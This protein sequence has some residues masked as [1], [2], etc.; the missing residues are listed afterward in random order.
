MPSSTLK[1]W[2]LHIALALLMVILVVV[3]YLVLQGFTLHLGRVRDLDT[4]ADKIQRIGREI[5][6]VVNSQTQLAKNTLDLL[7]ETRL[8]A[9]RQHHERLAVATSLATTLRNNPSA[10]SVYAGT[11]NGSFVMLRPLANDAARAAVQAPA[12]AAYLLQSVDRDDTTAVGSFF[13]FNQK[14]QALTS[15]IGKS[16]YQFDPRTRP[17]YS[18]AM[19]TE[20]GGQLV[21]T[22]PYAFFTTREI[23]IT[24]ASR[25]QDRHGVVGMDLNLSTLSAL[26]GR[27][28]ITA[29]AELVLFDA[30]GTVLAYPQ[31]KK[32]LK[33][34]PDGKLTPVTVTELA[35][36]VLAEVWQ[37]WQ[38][39]QSALEQ[40]KPGQAQ[41]SQNG[42]DWFYQVAPIG[43]G[44]SG[45][46]LGFAAPYSELM[47]ESIHIRNLS[48]GISLLLL[49][50]M[51]PAVF[52]AARSV[53][54]P[55]RGLTEVAAAIERFEFDGPDPAPSRITEVDR[56]ARSMRQMKHTLKRFLD[57]S[58]A[59]SSEGNFNK[60][61]H[62]ILRETISVTGAIGGSLALVSADGKRLE[63]QA[64]QLGGQE[65]EVALGGN[66]S[67]TT[68]DPMTQEVQAVLQSQLQSNRFDRND[69]AYV[70]NYGYLFDALDQDL[71]HRIALPLR[72]RAQEVIGVLT[73]SLPAPADA[74]AEPLSATLL[75]FIKAL[76]GTAAVAIDN[77][78]LLL[79]QKRLFES[80]IQLV[81]GS[82]DAKS[83]YTGG[84][85][86]R[87]PELTKMLAHAAQA[88][89]QGP[90]ADYRLSDDE[91]EALHIAG[92][93]HDCGK[94]TTPEFVVDKATKLETIYDRIH[95]VRMRF[96]VLK[97]DARIQAYEQALGQMPAELRAIQAEL[98]PLLA[99]L[100]EEFAFVATCNVG[101][102]FMAP[103]K[104]Q[105]LRN[106]AQRQWLRTL[107]DRAGISQDEALRKA[108]VPAEPLPVWEPLLADKPDQ[109]FTR[110]A[111]ERIEADN[112]WGFKI[113]P[114]EYL[115]HRGELHNLSVGR[116]TLTE[117]DRYKINEHIVQT[118]KMLAQL[119]FPKHLQRV[120]EIA[121]GHH[122]KMDGS[123]YPRKLRREE[124]SLEA[125]MMAIADVFEALTAVDR[126]YKKGK[127]LS[128][129]V[130]I[131]G[132][133]KKDQHIDAEL[134]ELFLTSGIYLEYAQRFMR[135]EQI[136]TVEVTAYLSPKQG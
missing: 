3:F 97:R 20:A 74:Q 77:Q 60:L 56:L 38:S 72:N 55:L 30:K 9:P 111:R 117:E 100:D 89:T 122:E 124:M 62:V 70:Q 96:E 82:I 39:G 92:W 102:E 136:D 121:A 90:F 135:P 88:Q 15:E 133:M 79:D 58:S 45:L 131:M 19:A 26:L 94:L 80:L 68:D 86:A 129:A 10:S 49:L 8:M 87:V 128:E 40:T 85:C 36:P 41:I 52:L 67:L 37:R 83:A 112:R 44:N 91:W 11:S 18:L 53:S 75:A 47:A 118:I 101:G 127:M 48:I 120:P 7:V 33:T 4:T 93:L 14:M 78:K 105:R 114:P 32:L 27:Q 99:Q 125:R 1:S 98:A 12:D 22:P 23:G 71:L 21:R 106:I 59:L 81:A 2:P 24:L 95:E 65:Q 57:I 66:F 126:P 84:H 34:L 17:W 134:F 73:L 46:Y 25:N 108:L 132:F 130:K 50:L 54:K 107:D 69:P 113:S 104:V 51:L 123:G 28:K 5:S 61:L 115:Y 110:P 76:S 13:F 116:G 119:P 103:D 16:D 6:E 109:I 42:E 31:T 43:D 64:R 63:V 35:V 29:S